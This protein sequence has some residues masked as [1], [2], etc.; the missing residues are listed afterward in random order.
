MH[1][2]RRGMA[3]FCIIL[4]EPEKPLKIMSSRDRNLQPLLGKR[5]REMEALD[6]LNPRWI[7]TQVVAAVDPAC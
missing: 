3:L 4:I 6:N 2:P 1:H 5:N 7:S